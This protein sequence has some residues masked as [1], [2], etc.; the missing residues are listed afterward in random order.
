[1]EK[2]QYI[3]PAVMIVQMNTADGILLTASDGNNTILEDGGD[4]SDADI[5]YGNAKEQGDWN[6]WE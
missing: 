2:K 1:M 6:I 4:T 3:M 5:S